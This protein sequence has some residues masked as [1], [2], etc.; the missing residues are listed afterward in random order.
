MPETVPVA[1]CPHGKVPFAEE[2]M[3]QVPGQRREV[4]F[5]EGAGSPALQAGWAYSVHPYVYYHGME[6]KQEG[7]GKA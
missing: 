7:E 6:C 1:A 3:I 4:K 5:R 2:P